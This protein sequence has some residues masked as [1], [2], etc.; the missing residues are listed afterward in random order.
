MLSVI[1]PFHRNRVQLEAVLTAIRRSVTRAEII[2][3]SDGA[4]ED[5]RAAVASVGAR[6]LV[7]AE[8]KGPAAARNWGASAATGSYLAFVDSDVEV[9]HDA[10]PGLCGILDR[11]SEVAGVFGAYDRSPRHQAF[12]SRYRNLAHT[13]VHEQGASDA[14]TFW[15]GLGVLRA[16]AFRAVGGFD[17]RFTSPSIEDIELGQRLSA[18]GYRLRL[19][20]RWRGC[21]LKQ[22]SLRSV[23]RT[24]IASRGVPWSLLLLR[25]MRSIPADLNLT[26]RLR[27]SAI[28]TF[29]ALLQASF[30]CLASD[31]TT[32]WLALVTWGGAAAL[33]ARFY[34]WC[35]RRYGFVFAVG[36]VLAHSLHHLC[37]VVSAVVALALL[38][39]STWGVVLPGTAHLLMAPS[40]GPPGLRHP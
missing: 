5:C 14:W 26:W 19:D 38:R 12:W 29:A 6:L 16:E 40:G 7:S 4:T 35:H 30:A 23:V 22:W 10:L 31:P 20:P 11:E 9:A 33:N 32:G 15:A 36:A 37:N 27:A 17:E 39:A 28:L 13:Y 2:V 1:V 34:A 24:D 3:I 8:A 18:A 25:R 21:H